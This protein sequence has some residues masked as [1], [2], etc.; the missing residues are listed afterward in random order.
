[1]I[2]KKQ[3]TVESM[4][5]YIKKHQLPITGTTKISFIASKFPNKTCKKCAS[6]DACDLRCILRDFPPALRSGWILS[7]FLGSDP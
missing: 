6:K 7:K 2:G 4:K 1:M 3:Q 5:E